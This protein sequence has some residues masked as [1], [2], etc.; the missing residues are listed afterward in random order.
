MLLRELV[1]QVKLYTVMVRGGE[2]RDGEG[3]GRK[4]WQR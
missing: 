2:R 3:K 4:A 1:V